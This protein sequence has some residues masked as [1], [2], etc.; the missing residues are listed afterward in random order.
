M[1]KTYSHLILQINLL[2]T[3]IFSSTVLWAKNEII[4]VHDFNA[5]ETRLLNSAVINP[6]INPISNIVQQPAVPKKH[7][8]SLTELRQNPQLF[9][10]LLNQAIRDRQWSLVKKLVPIYAL[11]PQHDPY[12]VLYAQAAVYWNE[13]NYTQALNALEQLL[14]AKPNLD[15]VRLD[16]VRVLIEDKQ[17]GEAQQQLQYLITNGNAITK[18]IAQAAVKQVD[19]LLDVQWDLSA[20][21]TRNDNINQ[22]SSIPVIYL[23]GVP[24][25]KD[26]DSMPKSGQGI[27]YNLNMTKLLPL[28]GHHYLNADLSYNGTEYWD[29]R[30]YSENTLRVSPGYLYQRHQQSFRLAPTYEY[31][32]LGGSRYGYNMGFE[33]VFTH[34]LNEQ[35]VLIPYFSYMY[36][37]YYAD[38]LNA[39]E[40]R[41][42]VGGLTWGYQ[43]LPNWRVSIGADY[44]YDDLKGAAESS[45][46][47]AGRVGTYFRW[48][49]GLNTQLS[50]RIAKRQFMQ[51]HF[52]FNQVR[53]DWDYLSSVSLWHE[54][55]SYKGFVP[56]LVYY[57]RKVDSN[58]PALYSWNSKGVR[59][60][61]S[62]SF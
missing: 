37:H 7:I 43:V 61:I 42:Y 35:H 28:I 15:Y 26:A 21:Y 25:Y 32:W 55:L 19:Q 38:N 51:E 58:I 8:I 56:K 3:L 57:Y 17:F 41:R 60:E 27:T 47:T 18:P 50:V 59:L 30:E 5:D 23:W 53:K 16:F 14:T 48:R 40:G 9:S 34:N 22:A 36:K 54:K 46:T 20:Y 31:N 10:L 11:L 44:Q 39:Y 62:K 49:N 4:Q 33:M 24:F 12:L 6:S 52:L 29:A 2:I 45:H 13:G 1:K